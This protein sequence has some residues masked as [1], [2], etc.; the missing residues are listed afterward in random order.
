MRSAARSAI[1]CFASTFAFFA[2][3]VGKFRLTA[4]TD[5]GAAVRLDDVPFFFQ[6]IQIAPNSFFGNVEYFGEFAYDNVPFF[7]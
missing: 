1:F 7:P 5:D 6:F 3:H 4:L 2:D